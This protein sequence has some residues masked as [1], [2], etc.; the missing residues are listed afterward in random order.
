MKPNHYYLCTKECIHNGFTFKE[1][2]FYDTDIYGDLVDD[3]EIS[4]HISE[5]LKENFIDGD[6]VKYYLTPKGCLSCILD[7]LGILS[8]NR[9]LDVCFFVLETRMKQNGFVVGEPNKGCKTTETPESIFKKT[10]PL[11][12]D[13]DD[14]TVDAAWIL[15]RDLII[16]Q[17]DGSN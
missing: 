7:D 5:N 16:K 9:K 10:I 11:F 17:Q 1:E 6:E 2:E 12:Y 3:I 8:D 4:H 15:F 13:I 14:N